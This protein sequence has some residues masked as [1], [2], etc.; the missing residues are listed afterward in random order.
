SQFAEPPRDCA[1]VRYTRTERCVCGVCVA[2]CCVGRRCGVWC[3]SVWSP[4]NCGS[5]R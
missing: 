4:G 3:V 1:R 2:V 5:I